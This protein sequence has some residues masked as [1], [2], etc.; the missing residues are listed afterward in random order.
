ML[1]IL[2]DIF[3]FVLLAA[4][5]G[6]CPP[7]PDRP[8]QPNGRF[9]SDGSSRSQW[10]GSTEIK[11]IIPTSAL[12][13]IYGIYAYMRVKCSALNFQNGGEVREALVAGE[14]MSKLG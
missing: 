14:V 10:R 12:L 8:M 4:C 6:V 13:P 11:V 1:L 9:L 7:G 5:T 2:N 3:L